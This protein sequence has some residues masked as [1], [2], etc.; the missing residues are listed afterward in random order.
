M[1]EK[2]KLRNGKRMRFKGTFDRY[3][4]KPAYRGLPLETVCLKEIQDMQGEEVTDHLW[5]NHTK[6]FK[7]LGLLCPGDRIAFDARV[8]A[9][10]KR[11]RVEEEEEW[12]GRQVDYHL[13]RPTKLKVLVRVSPRDIYTVCEKCGFAN[14]LT[15]EW[16]R[17]CGVPFEQL[18]EQQ[19]EVEVVDPKLRQMTLEDEFM[20]IMKSIGAVRSKA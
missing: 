11:A 19:L 20:S 3:G 7:V 1:R 17:R 16:C 6:G 9:Y 12:G 14:R 4:L 5:F 13:T 10:T 8:G 15:A 18:E 2:L